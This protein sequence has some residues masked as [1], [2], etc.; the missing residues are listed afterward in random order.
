M[1]FVFLTTLIPAGLPSSIFSKSV[2]PSVSLYLSIVPMGTY[3]LAL[4]KVFWEKILSNDVFPK[5]AN[6][7]SISE[8]TVE[9]SQPSYI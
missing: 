5:I 9:K 6:G 1:F 4:S 7:F 3:S 8:I 2:H